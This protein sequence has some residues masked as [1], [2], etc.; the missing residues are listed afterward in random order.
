MGLKPVFDGA[1]FNVICTPQLRVGA[2]GRGKFAAT[3][4]AIV[5]SL[6]LGLSACSLGNSTR[7]GRLEPVGMRTQVRSA[8]RPAIDPATGTRPSRRLVSY[9]NP[10]RKGGGTYKIGSPYKI[11]GRWYS[12]RSQPRYDRIGRASW[13][14]RDFHGRKTANGELYD[15]NALSAAHPTL[16]L[17]SLVYVTNLAN[18]RTILVRVNDRGPYA[19]NRII[20]LS[21]RVADVLDFRR[22]G[23]ARVRVR[24]YGRAP[25]SGDDRMERRFL[26]AQSWYGRG[27]AIRQAQVYKRSPAR[28]AARPSRWWW[29]DTMMRGLGFGS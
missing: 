22:Q 16:P 13:Y 23:I 27:R 2:A 12:P 14:G 9:G 28:K 3:T 15:L 26:A 19:H 21:R 6:A 10:V 11:S 17:P 25:L 7:L 29:P 1:V 4:G 18:N 8:V 20:D 24:Y 5:V